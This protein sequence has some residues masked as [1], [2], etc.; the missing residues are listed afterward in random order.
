MRQ[1]PLEVRPTCSVGM[2]DGGSGGEMLRKKF[3]LASDLSL[4][5]LNHF[6]TL[7]LP[8]QPPH[9]SLLSNLSERDVRNVRK[10]EKNHLGGQ[11][12]PGW[13]ADCD[14]AM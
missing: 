4:R 3:L 5:V 6:V 11:G 9:L 12:S 13:S 8:W 2:V 14:E 7:L 10:I 1:L